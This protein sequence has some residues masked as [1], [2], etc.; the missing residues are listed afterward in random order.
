M[1][2]HN[3]I[4]LLGSNMGDKESNINQA[5]SHLS[6]NVGEIEKKTNIMYNNVIE[7]VSSNNFCNIALSINTSLSPIS[8][9]NEIKKIEKKMGRI[10]DSA[11]FGEYRDR[12]IDIDIVSFSRINYE[13]ERLLI[14]HNKHL[15]ERG[16]A[17][18]L[19]KELNI[20]EKHRL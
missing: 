4:L 17:I 3:V 2:L 15:F 16:F 9:L 1:S 8:L 10:N 13:C 5:I 14:P 20:L 6:T 11:Y 7:F 12:I 18:E 19:L